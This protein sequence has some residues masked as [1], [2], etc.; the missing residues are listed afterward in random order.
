MRYRRISMLTLGP[1]SRISCL[2][3]LSVLLV[4]SQTPPSL[5]GSLLWRLIGPFR[6]GRSVSVSGVPGSGTTFLFGSVDGGIWKTADAGTTW[7]PIFDGQPVASIGALEIAPSDP[8]IIYAGTGESDIRSNLASGDGVYK[9]TDGGGTWANVGLKETRQISRL[10]VDPRNPN[11]VIVAALGH[12][13]A[14]NDDRGIFV[15][16]DGGSSWKKTLFKGPAIG[17]ADI[18]ISAD[19]P[20][21]VF[22]ALW[23]AHRPPWS[24][25]A[26]IAGAGS[27]LYRSVDG[28]HSWEPLTAH[29]LPE[30]KLGR[31]G[32]A[33]AKG[34]SS[35]R[36]YVSVDAGPDASGLYRS[37]DG[38]VS[39]KR[40]NAD[41]RITSRA[42][43][44]SSITADPKD[45]DVVYI[46]NVALFKLAGGGTD[47]SIVRGAPGGDDYHQLWIDPVNSKRMALASDQGTVVSV[48]GGASWTTW[49]NQPTAQLYHVITDNAYPYNLYAS[50]QDSGTAALPSRTDHG[51]IDASDFTTVGGSESGYIAPDPQDANVFYVTGTFGTVERF[52]RRTRESQNIAPWPGPSNFGTPSERKYRDPWTPM[53]VF[54]PI[55]HNAL[56]LG[57]QYVMRT[58][59]G[60]LHWQTLSPDLTGAENLNDKS[61]VTADNAKQL[62][63]GVVYSI[64]PS[65]LVADQIWAGT[66]TGLVHLTRNAGKTWANV[67]PPEVT[68]WSKITHIEASRF[69]PSEAFIAIDRHRLDDRGPHAFRTRDFGKTWQPIVTGIGDH[70]FLNVIREDPKRKG[71]L[72]AGTEFGVYVSWNDGDRWQPLQLNLPTTSVRDLAIHDNDLIAATHGRSFWVLDDIAILRQMSNTPEA[73]TRL[74]APSRAVRTISDTFQG[75]P[76]PV[77]EPKAENPPFGAYVDYYLST[78]VTGP[79][80]LDFLNSAGEVVRRY[81]SKDK[82]PVPSTQ[83]AIAPRW[84]HKAPA[85]SAE[86]GLHRFVWDLRYERSSDGSVDDDDNDN[87]N[88][89]GPV[90]LPGTYKVRLT[91]NEGKL[92]Q[93]L[94]IIL[95]P[96]SV[97]TPTG[98]LQQFTWAKRAF[99]D[100]VAARKATA[101]LAAARSKQ[102]KPVPDLESIG[103]ELAA[104]T[105]ALTAALTAME[106]SDRTPP[107]QVISLYQQSAATLRSIHQ[108]SGKIYPVSP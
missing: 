11:H 24:T 6:G 61:P 78:S 26:P 69:S 108:R 15:S 81:S 36:V 39:W 79:I 9:S 25:Y 77:D 12:A 91:T 50:Q 89:P 20:N 75:T 44:F 57:T 99:Q 1:L 33:I 80:T 106:S 35:Q 66:D 85:L 90:V 30:T 31:M 94:T 65:P 103:K 21:I 42:W 104:V 41:P 53:L 2:A 88:Y 3:S 70:S 100:V 60:G 56:Y 74:F 83:V 29:G 95:D 45:P 97:A 8:N 86:P 98:L 71:L 27:G 73:V 40:V 23:E 19:N 72:F 101:D 52:D 5:S 105:R 4:F 18:A 28:G 63:Y 10:A 84:L 55:Q 51:Q 102:T 62:G 16:D 14:P 32:I 54:S 13:Y 58:L 43:Y 37:D 107:S 92:E 38:G 67:T 64:A 82:I 96:R 34:T 68:P 87:A 47:L 46:P 59:D 76:L 49:Y 22:A 93:A 17:A 7:S 48:D